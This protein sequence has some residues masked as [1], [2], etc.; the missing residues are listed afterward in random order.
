MAIV[1]AVMS[2]RSRSGRALVAG[3]AL[4]AVAV[5]V[6]GAGVGL[7][8]CAAHVTTTPDDVAAAVRGKTGAPP[9]V[10]GSTSDR[11]GVSFELPANV[12][13]DDGVT[14]DEAVAIALWNN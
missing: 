11:G 3:I 7:T 13:L 5:A 6:A 2:R 1:T 12:G 14:A 8:G 4:A 10:I 9:R